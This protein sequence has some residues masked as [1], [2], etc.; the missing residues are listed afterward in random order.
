MKQILG[1]PSWIQTKANS[2]ICVDVPGVPRQTQLPH[3]CKDFCCRQS[4]RH[5]WAFFRLFPRFDRRWR[6]RQELALF[7]FFEYCCN[8]ILERLWYSP[9]NRHLTIFIKPDTTSMISMIRCKHYDIIL[10]ILLWIP[11]CHTQD[12]LDHASHCVS[13]S[14]SPLSLLLFTSSSCVK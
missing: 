6:A 11:L 5:S 14:T 8:L 4:F 1:N 13:S 12:T 10:L 7:S 2:H 3:H 9:L